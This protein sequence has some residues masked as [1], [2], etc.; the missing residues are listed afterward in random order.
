[1]EIHSDCSKDPSDE[2]QKK[3]LGSILN[4]E[5]HFED[6]HPQVV[7]NSDNLLPKSKWFHQKQRVERKFHD[8]EELVKYMSN[9]PSF[10][11]RG[12]NKKAFNLGVLD[13][14]LLEK[15]QHANKD[16]TQ[17]NVMHLPSSSNTS[18]SLPCN[19]AKDDIFQSKMGISESRKGKGSLT[20]SR[21]ERSSGSLA[22][23]VAENDFSKVQTVISESGNGKGNIT[24]NQ[25]EKNVAKNDFSKVKTGISESTKVRN[26]SPNRR[27]SFGLDRIG[28]SSSS[29]NLQSGDTTCEKSNATSRARSPLRR[30]LDPLL[31]PKGSGDSNQFTKSIGKSPSRIDRTSNSVKVKGPQQSEKNGSSSTK[32]ALLQVTLKNGL[33]LY[34]FTVDNNSDILAATVKDLTSSKKV[35]PRWVYTFFSFSETKKRSVNWINQGCKDSNHAYIPNVIAQM[36][37]SDI[38]CT[39]KS[40]KREFVLSSMST[41]DVDHISDSLPNDELAA[42]IVKFPENIIGQEH[43][44]CH[45]ND[46]VFSLT[47]ILPGGDHGVPRKGDPSPLIERWQSG[48]SCDCGGWDLGCR[49]RILDNSNQSNQRRPNSTKFQSATFKL[50]SQEEMEESKLIFNLSPFEDG[51]FSVEFDSSLKL[52]QAF[53]VGIAVLNSSNTWAIFSEDIRLSKNNAATKISNRGRVEVPTKYVSYPP[54]S[55]VGRV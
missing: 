34:T 52:I 41:K 8:S 39:I 36:K 15:W 29:E 21:E 24:V 44:D 50:F 1:M 3:K 20:V 32:Q 26:P 43:K 11:E 19:V 37:V 10:L 27:F 51:I 14:R 31:K 25:E 30:L 48:G 35:V 12:E 16:L 47:V 4:F 18:S 42:I 22:R 9:L 40:N 49:L 5:K 23:K 7:K 54:L 28:K 6:I 2:K 38:P 46:D 17:V 53:S 33:P 13:W 45:Q 55:P